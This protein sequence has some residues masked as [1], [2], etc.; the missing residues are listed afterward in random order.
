MVHFA[1]LNLVTTVT[2]VHCGTLTVWNG[3]IAVEDSES[4]TSAMH[5]A[6]DTDVESHGYFSFSTPSIFTLLHKKAK[7]Y[8]LNKRAWKLLSVVRN[9]AN[10]ARNMSRTMLDNVRHGINTEQRSAGFHKVL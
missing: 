3:W 1:I 9:L 4:V 2:V 5:L 7:R 6:S 10:V 8:L